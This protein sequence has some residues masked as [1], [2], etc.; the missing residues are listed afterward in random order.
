MDVD[1]AIYNLEKRD[2]N[3]MRLQEMIQEI[4]NM[5]PSTAYELVRIIERIAGVAETEYTYGKQDA[6]DD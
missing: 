1:Q 3:R 2:R 5:R 4:Y 6:S